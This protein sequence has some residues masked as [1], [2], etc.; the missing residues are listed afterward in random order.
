[1]GHEDA[2]DT[3]LSV[4]TSAALCSSLHLAVSPDALTTDTCCTRRI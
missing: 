2:K 4:S 3:C 1:M